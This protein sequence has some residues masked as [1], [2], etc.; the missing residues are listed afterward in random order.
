MTNA[1]SRHNELL[2]AAQAAL[3]FK[4]SGRAPGRPNRTHAPCRSPASPRHQAQPWSQCLLPR[5]EAPAS[6][7][8]M[9]A[10]DIG[11]SRKTLQIRS[12][13]QGLNR[14][15]MGQSSR[16]CSNIRGMLR[17][18]SSSS[19]LTSVSWPISTHWPERGGSDGRTT[20]PASLPSGVCFVALKL[21]N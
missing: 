15:P 12:I 19:G 5:C 16:S 20:V 6:S 13:A 1:G 4:V 11:S 8:A 21:P 9:A 3:I 2:L 7:R 14:A 10:S 18:C 17:T